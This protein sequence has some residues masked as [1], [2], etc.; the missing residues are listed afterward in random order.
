MINQLPDQ[1]PCA[2]PDSEQSISPPATG[3]G[4]PACHNA[5]RH[6]RCSR[7]LRLSPKE[8]GE[9]NDL[10]ECYGRDLQP[11]DDVEETLVNE[12]CFN[13]W[14]LQQAREAELQIIIKH[15]T[16]FNIIA[17]YLR[18]RTGYERSFYKALDKL[19]QAQRLRKQQTG[20]QDVPLSTASA[21]VPVRSEKLSDTPAER[22]ATA[23][24]SLKSAGP[25]ESL[26]ERTIVSAPPAP[27]S[28]RF[29]N[30]VAIKS[31]QLQEQIND[32]LLENRVR[33][34]LLLGPLPLP[35][36]LKKRVDEFVSQNPTLSHKELNQLLKR[37]A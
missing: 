4:I 22:P 27:A 16:E 24:R 10:R 20:K 6:D 21:A 37:A 11:A 35:K 9:Y 33:A 29:E 17:L 30:S 23:L 31:E 32:H 7:T 15:P 36:S 25:P 26:G 12:I 2:K 34:E 5:R 18:Y 13:Y 8:W 1:L 3:P 14:R 28:V 19:H